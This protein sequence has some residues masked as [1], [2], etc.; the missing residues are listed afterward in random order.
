MLELPF[1]SNLSCSPHKLSP[2]FPIFCLRAQALSPPGPSHTRRRGPAAPAPASSPRFWNEA[3]TF[4]I[5]R[6]CRRPARRPAPPRG[7]LLGGPDA[8]QR[9][10]PDVVGAQARRPRRRRAVRVA[11]RAARRPGGLGGL[12]ALQGHDI[13]ACGAAWG[14][15]GAASRVGR[16]LRPLGVASVFRQPLV[17]ARRCP[18]P[19][20]NAQR[21]SASHGGPHPVSTSEGSGTAQRCLCSRPGPVLVVFAYSDLRSTKAPLPT[22]R[23]APREPVSSLLL[24]RRLATPDSSCS[25]CSAYRLRAIAQGSGEQSHPSQTRRAHTN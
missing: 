7:Y 13:T 20:C 9:L 22:T 8:R 2:C 4:A 6:T 5:A 12:G 15:R 14:V 16:R 18:L 19:A 1:T 25:D 11:G 24:E 17:L 21:G 10:E 3:H 23:S